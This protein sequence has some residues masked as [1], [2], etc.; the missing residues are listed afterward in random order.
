MYES[1]LHLTLQRQKAL[2][3]LNHLRVRALG[4]CS[5]T[6]SSFRPQG[7]AVALD[8]I[9]AVGG[10]AS[11]SHRELLEKQKAGGLPP[12]THGT[13]NI[14]QQFSSLRYGFNFHLGHEVFS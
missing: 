5:V 6:S 10:A 3:S 7:G 12:V 9:G 13:C 2:H 14:F 1:R 11:S 8:G 4:V